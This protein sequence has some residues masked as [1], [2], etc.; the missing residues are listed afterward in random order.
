MKTLYESILASSHAGKAG[1]D[2][3]YEKYGIDP[4]WVTVNADG[5]ID[6]AG[7]IVISNQQMTKLPFRFNRVNGSMHIRSCG[8]TTLEGAP[9]Y[10]AHDFKVFNNNLTSLE[11]SPEYVGWEFGC[12]YNKIQTLKGGPKK[13]GKAYF[14]YNNE[15]TSLEGAPKNIHAEFNCSNNKLTS[16]KGCP[17]DVNGRFDCTNN[18]LTSFEHGP[19]KAK[20]YSVRNIFDI[21]NV[22]NITKEILKYTKTLKIELT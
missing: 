6:Y 20:Y 18:P 1:V 16:L 7:T 17:E 12:S 11:G 2:A 21:S 14:C 4:D 19:K 5:T 13:V 8:L 22:K 15:L 9:K 3:L 10:V